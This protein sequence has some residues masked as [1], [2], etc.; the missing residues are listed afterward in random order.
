MIGFMVSKINDNSG[1]RIMTGKLLLHFWREG[2]PWEREVDISRPAV[3]LLTGFLLP[4]ALDSLCFFRTHQASFPVGKDR[5]RW[6]TGYVEKGEVVLG[7]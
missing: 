3:L 5:N 4:L 6:R 7:V 2:N 1:G